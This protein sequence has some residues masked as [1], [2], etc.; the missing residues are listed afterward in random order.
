VAVKL[1]LNKRG[2]GQIRIE[3]HGKKNP[4]A[5]APPGKSI[6]FVDI[7]AA[8]NSFESA[9]VRIQYTEGELGSMDE[10]ALVIYHWNGAVWE[11]LAT[12]ADTVNNIL[13]A[14]ATSLSPFA[15]SSGEGGTAQ[16]LV[17]TNRY[18]ILDD[19]KTGSFG[20]GFGNPGSSS[21]GNFWNGKNTTINAT[22]MYI[23][24]SGTPVAG[25]Q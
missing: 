14:T 6:K 18:V 21:N 20:T 1:K 22:A 9:E 19:G 4:V 17:A 24:N 10:N 12:S 25:K 2:N 23:D 8:D 5:V 7:S 16:I 3:D 15:V 11:A 13:T